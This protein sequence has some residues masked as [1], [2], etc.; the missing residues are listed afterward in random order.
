MT[1]LWNYYPFHN[2][3][4]FFI[5]QLIIKDSPFLYRVTQPLFVGGLVTYYMQ[6][7]GN[8]SEAYWYAGGV[9]LCSALNVLT[10]HAFMLGQFHCGMKIRISL[11]SI[12]YRKALRLS[13][14]ALGNTTAGQ[15]VNLLS[16]DVGKFD[17]ALIGMHQLWVGPLEIA[18]VV[19]IIYQHVS[20]VTG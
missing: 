19:F 9:I 2:Q 1:P 7:D 15:I 5:L 11:I 10:Q 18:L 14:T 6:P 16:N 12:I 4:H 8:I 3:I 20:K 13:Q 17:S